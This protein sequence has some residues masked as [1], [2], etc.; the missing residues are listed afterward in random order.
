[1]RKKV[2]HDTIDAKP[3][4]KSLAE[5]YNPEVFYG[6]RG[7]DGNEIFGLCFEELNAYSLILQRNLNVPKHRKHGNY[8][9][10]T[11][12]VF[13]YGEY[14]QRNKIETVNSILSED[15]VQM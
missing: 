4:I 8:R 9:K 10:R 14:L 3:M 15:L 11:C 7:Y 12:N 13:D 6:D 1:M 5:H 2:R